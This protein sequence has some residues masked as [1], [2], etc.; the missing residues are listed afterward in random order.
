MPEEY[1]NLE[2]IARADDALIRK[3]P[4]ERQGATFFL[5]EF[6]NSYKIAD[7]IAH[8]PTPERNFDIAIEKSG[9]GLKL[10]LQKEDGSK[11]DLNEYM[12]DG[13]K[14]VEIP[15]HVDP[16]GINRK[17]KEVYFSREGLASQRGAFLSLLH[18][19]GH[20]YQTYKL[21]EKPTP[22]QGLELSKNLIL[23]G[24]KI[25]KHRLQ[26]REA[27]AER[28]FGKQGDFQESRKDVLPDSFL[29][30]FDAMYAKNER[31][32]WAVALRNARDLEKEGFDVLAG[33]ENGQEVRDYIAANLFTYEYKR[34]S[35]RLER[36]GEEGM[37]NFT[38]Y[39]VRT[40]KAK[41]SRQKMQEPSSG[42]K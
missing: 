26:R 37:D 22:G 14:L 16:F 29:D 35:R 17:K 20:T 18:E 12:A 13:Y 8:A 40:K 10:T 3:L 1:S 33:F 31:D 24:A 4:A 19:F 36:Y 41:K 34:L 9:D 21:T 28:E 30:K 5:K 42:S 6:Y 2:T 7:E 38:P 23:A 11:K 39:Y 32:A 27:S 15:S 25:F